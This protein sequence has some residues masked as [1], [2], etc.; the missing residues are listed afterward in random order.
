MFYKT[1]YITLIR[2]Y[3]IIKPLLITF[4]RLLIN[5]RRKSKQHLLK[6]HILTV[7]DLEYIKPQVVLYLAGQA[8][9]GYQGNMW[10]N[11]LEKID[12]KVAVVVRDYR[13]LY[14]LDKT[15]LPIVFIGKLSDLELIEQFGVKTIL[16]PSNTTK[17]SQSLRLYRL[18][19]YFINHGESDKVVNQSK[20][21][22]AYDKLLLSGNLAHQRLIEAKL[23]LRDNH[24]VFVGRPQVEL[25]LEIQHVKQIKSVL[26]APTWEGFVEEANYT[27]I[28]EFGLLLMKNLA[29][30]SQEITVY[31]KPHPFTA[32]TKRNNIQEHYAKMINITK[33]SNIK[34]IESNNSIYEY[35]NCSDLM[36]TDI[37]SVITD[38]LYTQKPMILTNPKEYTH[39]DI[40]LNFPSSQ[41]LYILDNPNKI[42]EMLS[43]IQDNDFL[44]DTR[45]AIKNDILGDIKE[46]YLNKFNQVINDSIDFKI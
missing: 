18:N 21:L 8:N 45:I 13:I 6:N 25:F 30:L 20:L 16:Y 4:K 7:Y 12:A 39:Q 46:G 35:M 38:F 36:I 43:E 9:S 5:I 22:M 10:F 1:L 14:G 19:H 32:I 28:G 33:E 27:S 24:V 31:F 15:S 29:L 44:K 34:F 37:S 40:Y 41:A 2:I 42:S 17:V 3:K 23:P 11:V 26:Y